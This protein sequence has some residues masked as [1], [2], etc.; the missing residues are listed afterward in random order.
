MAPL[1][2][3]T[4]RQRL[5][6]GVVSLFLLVILSPLVPAADSTIS[7][8]TTW[9]GEMVLSGNITVAS[10]TTLTIAP[11]TNV[12]AREYSIV[13]E[14]ALMVEGASFFSSV[15]PITQGSHGQ[16]LWPGIVVELSLIHI[17]EPTRP[18]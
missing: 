6:C 1:Q 11:G 16:G 12:D 7:A 2:R 3:N 5:A 14:G 15:P 9:S 10:G 18:S 4:M 17:S 8:D 13:V